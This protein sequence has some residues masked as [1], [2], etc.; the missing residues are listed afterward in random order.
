MNVYR[1]NPLMPA[2]CLKSLKMAVSLVH[3][4][5]LYKIDTLMYKVYRPH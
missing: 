1:L 2:Y 3:A 5:Y 4:V